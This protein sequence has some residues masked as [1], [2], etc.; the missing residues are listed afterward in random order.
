MNSILQCIVHTP[1]LRN[2]FITGIFQSHIN[3]KSPI[4]KGIFSEVIAEFLKEYATLND[5]ISSLRKVKTAIGKYIPQFQ[6]YDQ[7]DAQEVNI[8]H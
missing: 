6:G 2:Y 8:D 1:L 5:P 7:H 3:K 4:S